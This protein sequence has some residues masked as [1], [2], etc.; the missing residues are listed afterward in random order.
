MLMHHHTTAD[1]PSQKPKK[2][3]G[4]NKTLAHSQ[5]FSYSK[6]KNPLQYT[7]GDIK[8]VLAWNHRITADNIATSQNDDYQSDN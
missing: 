4:N 8:D 5:T 7:L 3:E 2:L 1:I 6:N